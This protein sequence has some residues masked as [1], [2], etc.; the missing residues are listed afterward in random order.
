MDKEVSFES[1]HFAE[2]RFRRAYMGTWTSPAW[3]RG[4]RCVVKE[5]K[6][7]FT[8][9][10]SDWDTTKLVQE[11]A[12]EMAKG[13]NVYSQTN[14]RTN[15]PAIK[16]TEMDVMQVVSRTDPKAT[17][18]VGESVI[19]E[20]YIKGNFK[21]W[22]N[23][24]GFISEE[25]QK[26]AISMPAFMHWSWWKNDGQMMIA[27]LQGVKQENGYLL[28]DPVILSDDNQYG[29]TDMGVEGMAM[30]FIKHRCNSLCESLPAPKFEDFVSQIS[31][32]T[33]ML[34]RTA[35]PCTQNCT[36]FVSELKFTRPVK[37]AVLHTFRD[38]ATRAR[39]SCYQ[40]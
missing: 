34:C 2:G 14:S 35:I 30:F 13:F 23:N 36:A 21:K 24:Y 6:D 39:M 10:P 16:F 32:Q 18:R 4:Q 5:L 17:P 19:V 38:V 26:T 27:D 15:Y 29:C 11:E 31:P 3:K 28:T 8:W 7:D 1:K 37:D 40:S 20:E 33:L 22:C 25:A 12:Q 9:K